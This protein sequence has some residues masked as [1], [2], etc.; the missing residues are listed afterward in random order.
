MKNIKTAAVLAA[1]VLLVSISLLC[2]TSCSSVPDPR[3]TVEA[4][5]AAV[6]SYDTD[7]MEAYWGRAFSNMDGKSVTAKKI[8]SGLSYRIVSHSVEGENATVTVEISNTDMAAL[9]SKLMEE[10]SYEG[11]ASQDE[12]DRRLAQ[13]LCRPGNPRIAATVGID[14]ELSDGSWVISEDNSSAVYAMLGGMCSLEAICPG[15]VTVPVAVELSGGIVL[16]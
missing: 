10:L 8:C 13:L 7:G 1:T 12:T 5:F 15:A 14:L 6:K 4:A 11:T 9:G 16:N 2:L 3:K